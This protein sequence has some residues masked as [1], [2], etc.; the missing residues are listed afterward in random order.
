M[1]HKDKI[2]MELDYNYPIK[3]NSQIRRVNEEIF[4][5]K[6]KY[7]K[8]IKDNFD[9]GI[10]TKM[11]EFEVGKFCFIKIKSLPKSVKPLYFR[12]QGMYPVYLGPFVIGALHSS[13]CGKHISAGLLTLD[14]KPLHF[15]TS[16]NHWVNCRRL[17]LAPIRQCRRTISKVKLPNTYTYDDF[18]TSTG[19]DKRK[20]ARSKK[21][22]R[23]EKDLIAPSGYYKIDFILDTKLDKTT[24]QRLYL[25][26]WSGF[27]IEEWID[28]HNLTPEAI[29]DYHA[30]ELDTADIYSDEE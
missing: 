22:G 9:K 17:K 23:S 26:K 7:K 5:D 1:P 14:L 24:G 16:K 4:P 2:F 25:V 10:R 20:I 21:I 29:R 13:P 18:I 11:P 30:L 28:E 12:N 19:Y 27:E 3:V 6:Q 8:I 15:L